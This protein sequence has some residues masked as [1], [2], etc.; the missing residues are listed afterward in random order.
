M[1]TYAEIINLPKMNSCEAKTNE[2]RDKT[3]VGLHVVAISDRQDNDHKQS[4]SK[5]L[6]KGQTGSA[7]LIILILFNKLN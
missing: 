3:R 6:V 5:D 4:C 1:Q 2:Q 7:N